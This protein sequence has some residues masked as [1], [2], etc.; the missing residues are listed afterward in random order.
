MTFESNTGQLGSGISVKGSST[1]DFNGITTFMNNSAI[2]GGAIHI[3]QF[4]TLALSNISI[5]FQG[6]TIFASNSAARGGA[7]YCQ[8]ENVSISFAGNTI[9][10]GNKA[11]EYGAHLT[12]FYCNSCIANFSGSTT[13]VG[14]SVLGG[15]ITATGNTLLMFNGINIFTQNSAMTQVGNIQTVQGATF[16]CYDHNIFTGNE[17]GV[18]MFHDSAMFTIS[19]ITFFGDNFNPTPYGAGAN[20]ALNSSGILQGYIKLLTTLHLNPFLG[21]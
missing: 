16:Q 12:F 3:F 8:G 9:F 7:I 11:E 14:V 20:F 18:F 19:G 13:V 17:G 1:L 5:H 6:L 21:L 15:V 4:D 2:E 10:T